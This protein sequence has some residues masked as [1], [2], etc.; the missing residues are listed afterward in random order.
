[1][2]DHEKMSESAAC[3]RQQPALKK[4][5]IAT[6]RRSDNAM[7]LRV[8]ESARERERARKSERARESARER[9]SENERC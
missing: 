7:R 3:P 8:R 6:I 5:K 4:K 9:A 1:V 2:G